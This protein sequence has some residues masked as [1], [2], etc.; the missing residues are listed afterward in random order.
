MQK[1]EEGIRNIERCS[2]LGEVYKRKEYMNNIGSIPP[3]N[4]KEKSEKEKAIGELLMKPENSGMLLHQFVQGGT[5]IPLLKKSWLFLEVDAEVLLEVLPYMLPSFIEHRGWGE[6][7][8][9]LPTTFPVFQNYIC[10]NLS[11]SGT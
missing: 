9:S 10:E 2:G 6:D 4:E 5:V 3:G 8:H 7:V 11:L 1:G